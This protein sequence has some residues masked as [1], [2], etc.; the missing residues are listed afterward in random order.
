MGVLYEVEGIDESISYF[1][2]KKLEDPKISK[3]EMDVERLTPKKLKVFKEVGL[4]N[5]MNIQYF[6]IYG[7]MV[8]FIYNHY[9]NDIFW[10]E[11]PY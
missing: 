3:A 7:N 10:M 5:L 1:Y 9:H 11:K 4:M 2:T 8:K 6:Y